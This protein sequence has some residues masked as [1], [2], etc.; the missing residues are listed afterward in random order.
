[1][2]ASRGDPIDSASPSIT[3]NQQPHSRLAHPRRGH[4]SQ[5]Q[6]GHRP[7]FAHAAFPVVKHRAALE[8]ADDEAILA[9]GVPHAYLSRAQE[10]L[11][12]KHQ[13]DSC[14]LSFSR[15]DDLKKHLTS[16][17][18][19]NLSL[20]EYL[21]VSQPSMLPPPGFRWVLVPVSEPIAT[22]PVHASHLPTAQPIVPNNHN[23]VASTLCHLPS[24]SA[25]Q[26]LPS[27]AIFS[28][29]PPLN[30][31]SVVM[32]D[33]EMFGGLAAAA[34]GLFEESM[35]TGSQLELAWSFL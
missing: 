14:Q 29:L 20:R 30:G 28:Q 13:C 32:G 5:H 25:P 11:R 8:E 35:T 26:T 15:G 12:K 27:A 34:P 18:H 31:N 16:A 1:M 9:A 19:Q 17:K 4:K 2:P 10:V 23:L 33:S 24:A 3:K 7:I 21:D 6:L 22:Y